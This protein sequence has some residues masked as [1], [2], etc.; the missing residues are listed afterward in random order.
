M[1]RKADCNLDNVNKPSNSA[2][3][4]HVRLHLHEILHGLAVSSPIM[5]GFAVEHRLN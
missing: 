3:S 4:A 5:V 2:F 1:I